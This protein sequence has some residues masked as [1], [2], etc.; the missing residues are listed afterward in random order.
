MPEF[1]VSMRCTVTKI[2]TVQCDNEDQARGDPFAY[3]T[4]EQEVDQLDYEVTGCICT[5][6]DD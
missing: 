4:F 3:A 1:E 5:E 6:S 2:V